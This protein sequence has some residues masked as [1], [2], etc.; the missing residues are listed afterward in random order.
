MQYALC[1]LCLCAIA[2]TAYTVV[3]YIQEIGQPDTCHVLNSLC[4]LPVFVSNV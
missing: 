3:A 1:A 2:V 4:Q